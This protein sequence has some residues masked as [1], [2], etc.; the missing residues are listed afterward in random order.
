MKEAS[1]GME[2]RETIHFNIKLCVVEN[3]PTRYIGKSALIQI[4]R[5]GAKLFTSQLSEIVKSEKR[6][7]CLMFF[8]KTYDFAKSIKKS[9]ISMKFLL[10][11]CLSLLLLVVSE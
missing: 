11:L 4:E 2:D 9:K 8:D 6:K 5:K 1:P 7:S 3:I 10:F